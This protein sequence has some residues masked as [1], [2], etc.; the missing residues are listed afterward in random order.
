M[1]KPPSEAMDFPHRAVSFP[2]GNPQEL[3]AGFC[4]AR[5]PDPS[6]RGHG[7][8]LVPRDNPSSPRV[9]APSWAA[10]VCQRAVSHGLPSCIMMCE[11]PPFVSMC[12]D[13]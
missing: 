12:N 10:T 7:R 9:G 11:N 5:L 8:W 1:E 13:V 2:Q 3:P 6:G 4:P